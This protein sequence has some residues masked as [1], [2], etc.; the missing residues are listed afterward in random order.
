MSLV[1]Y[2]GCLLVLALVAA[3]VRGSTRA[4]LLLVASFLFYASFDWR[5]PVLLACIIGLTYGGGFW[6]EQTKVRG[7]LAITVSIMTVLAPL[8]VYK[9]ILIWLSSMSELFPTS[10]LNFGGYGDVLIPVGLSFFTFQCLGYLIDIQRGAYPADRNVLRLGLFISFFPQL[11]A[12]PIERYAHLAEPLWSKCRPTPDMAMNGLLYIVYGLALKLVVADRLA[13]PVDMA[14]AEAGSSGVQGALYAFFGFYVQ[15]FGDFAGYSLIAIGAGLVFGVRLTDNFK[16]PLFASNIVDFWQRWHISLTRWVGDYIY[17]PVGLWTL[18]RRTWSTHQ[19]EAMTVFV[20]WAVIGMW[21]GANWTFL[22]FGLVQAAMILTYKAF[23]RLKG[24]DT[25]VGFVFGWMATF[26]FV[27]LSFGLVRTPDLASYLDLLRALAFW[28]PG[29][30]AVEQA[31]LVYVSIIVMFAIEAL[32]RFMNLSAMLR[33]F[34]LRGGLLT[35]GIVV[36]MSFGYES[37]R[38]FVYF[39]F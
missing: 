38:S 7:R 17:R 26:L 3:F 37:G 23:I 27:S 35:L 25:V 11:L 32:R 28:Q 29:Q 1:P 5:F 24:R 15:L 18:Q 33:S 30:V 14:F 12:G 36:L 22:V 6:V 2:V 16:Q 13:L 4:V 39:R 19:R 10:S 34:P 20:T 31:W 21:H 9:Y 8:A